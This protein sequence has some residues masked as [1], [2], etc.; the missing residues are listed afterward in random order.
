[1]KAG[2][3]EFTTTVT[4]QQKGTTFKRCV[5]PVEAKSVNGS[6]QEARAAT[7]KSSGKQCTLPEFNIVGDTVS[8]KLVCDSIAVKSTATYRGDSFEGQIT[9]NAGGKEVSS[10][11]KARLLGACP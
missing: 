6:A 10:H 1:M 3:W 8:Y 9:S 11:V 4:G 5:T 2:Q 7:E